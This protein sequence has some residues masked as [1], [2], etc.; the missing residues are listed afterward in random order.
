M[1]PFGAAL[2]RGQLILPD[3]RPLPDWEPG[4]PLPEEAFIEPVSDQVMHSVLVLAGRYPITPRRELGDPSEIVQRTTLEPD[5]PDDPAYG[6]LLE[7]GSFPRAGTDVIVL[8]DAVAPTAAVRAAVRIR[9]GSYDLRLDVIG[10][11]VWTRSWGRLVPSPPE[12]FGRM[13]IVWGRAFGGAAKGAYGPVP[14]A[15]NPLGRGYYLTEDEAEGKPLPNIEDPDHPVER[16]SDQPRPVG[17]GPYPS[18]WWL[19]LGRYVKIDPAAEAVRVQPEVGIFDRAHPH[20]SGQR[21]DGGE[22]VIEGMHASGR[23]V[24]AIPR[25]PAVVDIQVGD[26][27]G[28]RELTLDEIVVDLHRGYVDFTWRKGFTY[29]FKPHATRVTKVRTRNGG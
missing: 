24:L 15:A 13:P 6:I 20:L 1:T 3:D 10:D 22:I 12:S 21:V 23:I 19:R 14:F 28:T 7:P 8:G 9:V 26:R 18:N 16:W 25:C 29:R 2:Y 27:G 4:T 5:G 17:C 11:R